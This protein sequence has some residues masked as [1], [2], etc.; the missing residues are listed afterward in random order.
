M[1]TFEN[2]RKR[3]DKVSEFIGLN[4]EELDLLLNHEK[5][6]KDVLNVNG[7]NYDAWR[8]IHNNSIGPGK[9]GIR[10]HQDVSEDEVKSLSFWMSLKTSLVGLPFGG[11]KG[12]VKVNPKELNEKEIEELSRAYVRAFSEVIGMDKDIPAPDVYTSPKIMA[13]MLDEYEKVKDRHEPGMITGKPIELGGIALRSDATSKGGFIVLKE[14]L[15]KMKKKS[16]NMN[17]VIQGFG[18]AGSHLALMMYEDG[19]NIVAVSDSKGGVYDESGLDIPKIIELKDK[20][21]KVLDYGGEELTNDEI[22]ELNVDILILAALE[23]QITKENVDRIKAGC[24][25]ELANGPVSFEADE[26]LFEKGVEVIPD[27]LAN[28]GGVL[29]SYFEW[30]QNKIG[31]I[32]EEDFLKKKLEEMM[33]DAFDRV[34]NFCHGDSNDCIKSDMRTSSYIIAIRR[35]LDAERARGNL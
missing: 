3:L 16:K 27:I 14:F 13:F 18:N 12:G 25:L 28:A 20:G 21:K 1:S 8:I 5:I 34:Y 10:F 29:V 9:G 4:E 26:I 17:V 24:I 15:K 35:I 2:I 31:N 23:N 22:L 7:K 19:F 11:A 33:K 6:S 32:L 30:V